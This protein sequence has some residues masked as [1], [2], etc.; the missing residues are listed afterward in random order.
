VV[1]LTGDQARWYLGQRHELPGGDFDR[2]KRQ[3]Q[4]LRAVF[5]KLSSS[6]TLRSPG[7]LDAALRSLTGSVSVDSGLSDGDLLGLALSARDLR[8]SGL[9][10]LTAPVLGTG[11]EG[12]ASVVYLD[13][14][15]DARMWAYLNTDSLG[16]NAGEFAAQQLPD[17]PN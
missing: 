12:A 1:H 4:Y 2:E 7:T 11:R 6:G 3:Q 13:Q 17:V 16:Q 5:A 9:Q 8:P 15:A 10:F 14:A